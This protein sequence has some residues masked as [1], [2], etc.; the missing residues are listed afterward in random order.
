MNDSE[1]NYTFLTTCKAADISVVIL[2]KFPNEKYERYRIAALV[3]NCLLLFSTIALNGISIITIRKSSQLRSKVCYF[4]I[5]LQP[6][7][8]LGVGILGIPLFIYYLLLPFLDTSNCTLIILVYRTTLLTCALS[9]ITLSAMTIERYIGVLHPY[10]YETNVTRKRI[11]TYVCGG[12]LIVFSLMACSFRDTRIFKIGATGTTIAF[13]LLSG[14]VYTKIYLVIRKLIRSEKR[15]A[16]E[17]DGNQNNMKRQTI[18][19]S[20]HAR[21]C[22]LIVICFILFLVPLPLTPI[23][24]TTRSFDFIVC[25]NWSITSMI[26][27]SSINSV[28]FFWTKTLLRKE[29]FKTLKSLCS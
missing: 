15:P 27:N 24:F 16:C 26:L 10:H 23:L 9:V 29:A 18:R 6:V 11:S 13:L 17:S 1:K 4:V 12:S 22:F 21:S 3:A 19:E 28:I 25:F 7:V 14:F 20:R 5:L 8:D 2:R